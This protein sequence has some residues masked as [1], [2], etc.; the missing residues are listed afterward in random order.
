M[1]IIINKTNESINR[2]ELIINLFN[3]LKKE[4]KEKEDKKIFR[5]IAKK[6]KIN[7]KQYEEMLFL[8]RHQLLKYENEL[9]KETDD[10]EMSH[11][12]L[13]ENITLSRRIYE[14]ETVVRENNHINSLLQHNIQ[15]LKEEIHFL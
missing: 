10:N 13:K 11:S 14:L 3:I 9:Q 1:D 6:Q 12:L 7:K 15:I 5:M 2:T 8:V 4:T